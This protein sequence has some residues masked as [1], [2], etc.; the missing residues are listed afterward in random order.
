LIDGYARVRALRELG[1]D[2]VAACELAVSVEQALVLAHALA[3]SRP[4]TA[5]EEGWLLRELAESHGRD[6]REL[7]VMLDRSVSWVSRRLGLVRALPEK[8]QEAVGGGGWE[9]RRR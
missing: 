1:S 8:V 5:L 4:R 3:S 6:L 7:A 2:K 9:R